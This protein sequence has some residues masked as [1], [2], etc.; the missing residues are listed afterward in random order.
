MRTQTQ[1]NKGELDKQ[2]SHVNLELSEGSSRASGSV[3]DEIQSVGS[4]R[5]QERT[6]GWAESVAQQSG[7]RRPKYPIRSPLCIIDPPTN[8]TKARDGNVFSTSQKIIPLFH[9][10]VG[11]FP[12]LLTEPSLRKK[13]EIKKQII[14]QPQAPLTRTT[15]HQQG[16]SAFQIRYRSQ[17]LHNH[18]QNRSTESRNRSA[19]LWNQTTLQ[20]T[21]Q[22]EQ[23]CGASGLSN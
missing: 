15:F 9:L 22:P 3:A 13:T 17:F 12:A 18:S 8:F 6:G 7:I 23:S 20:V 1:K 19:A 4:G 21:Y 14:T 2:Q 10:D 5:N 16:T 11:L